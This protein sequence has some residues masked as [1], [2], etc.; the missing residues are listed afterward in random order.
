MYKK[1]DELLAMSLTKELY[2]LCLDYSPYEEFTF[3]EEDFESKKGMVGV[4]V[5]ILSGA[6]ETALEMLAQLIEG[7]RE[8]DGSQKEYNQ[9]VELRERIISF[10][11][12]QT[13]E[14]TVQVCLEKR[15]AWYKKTVD[16]AKRVIPIENG[17]EWPPEETDNP[18][19][20]W[21]GAIREIQ[22]TVDMLRHYQKKDERKTVYVLIEY[23]DTAIISC[24]PYE[25]YLYA[26]LAM[27]TAYHNTISPLSIDDYISESTFIE[28][29]RACIETYDADTS[30][31][32]EI[33]ES[34]VYNPEDADIL[35]DYNEYQTSWWAEMDAIDRREL[36]FSGEIKCPGGFIVFATYS[37]TCHHM[38]FTVGKEHKTDSN[39]IEALRWCRSQGIRPASSLKVANRFLREIDGSATFNH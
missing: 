28:E 9:A 16:I 8:E 25:L 10:S 27:E 23:N 17:F 34:Y 31:C 32:W 35:L 24:E 11:R 4:A 3:D 7:F 2:K 38:W 12:G 37:P 14:E 22:N 1:E 21:T 36:I 15:L 29:G 13:S 20:E 18:L 39:H 19:S 33:C 30:C 6:P 26:K 5:E